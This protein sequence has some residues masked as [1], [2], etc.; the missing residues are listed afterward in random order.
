MRVGTRGLGS[1]LRRRARAVSLIPL[2]PGSPPGVFNGTVM[3][4]RKRIDRRGHE[5]QGGLRMVGFA[6]CAE[7]AVALSLTA[8]AVGLH[9]VFLTHA[10][11]LWRDEAS[12]VWLATMPTLGDVWRGLPFDHCPPMIQLAIRAWTQLGLAD[13]DLHLRGLGFL[14]GLLLLAACWTATWMTRRRPPVLPLALLGLNATMIAVGDSFRGYGLGATLAILVFA[15]MW[16]LA[17]RPGWSR[18]VQAALAGGLSVQC[19]YQNAIF[20]L[21]A[22]C[23]AAAVMLVRR[24]WREIRW[25]LGVGV[26]S[27]AALAPYLPIVYRSQE[28]YVLEKAGFRWTGGWE[29]LS[30]AMGH[31]T[32]AIS[33]VWVSLCAIALLAAGVAVARRLPESASAGGGDLAAYAGTAMV[34]SGAAFAVFLKAAD[35]PTQTWYYTTLMAFVALCLDAILATA[36]R[37]ARPALGVLAVGIGVLALAGGRGALESRRTNIDT[38]AARVG[39]EATGGDLVIVHP[40]YCGATFAR[41]YTGAAAWTTLPP[42]ADHRLH[43][44][45]L[46]KVELQ[47][48][49]PIAPVLER[50]AAT[51][52]AGHRVWL[53]GWIPLDGTPP[54][55]IRPAPDNPWGWFDESYSIVWAM[56]AGYFIARHATQGEVVSAPSPSGVSSFENLGAYVVGGWH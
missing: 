2:G 33:W 1:S 54:P 30:L 36:H 19:L 9:V 11:A 24:R 12:M 46:L 52:R 14:L 44:Y 28:W 21:A 27:A 18:A 10:G 7:W 50:V 20:V 41:Y 39:S 48:P 25:P 47:K 56:Q 26:I 3:A 35:L 51:L 43:R 34:V 22:A 31:P 16:R 29:N 32:A 42:L 15:T 38:L 45:D 8:L 5:A 6:G 55:E 17:R 23:G 13:S 4:D 37:W 53:V 40:W 49:Q